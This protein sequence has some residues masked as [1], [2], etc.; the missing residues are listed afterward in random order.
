[1]G[2]TIF[3][4]C[5]QEADISNEIHAKITEEQDSAAEIR[6]KITEEAEPNFIKKKVLHFKSF[7]T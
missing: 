1:M 4:C 2:Q 7:K 6:A 5:K 3:T